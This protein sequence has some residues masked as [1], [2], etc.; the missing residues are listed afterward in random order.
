MIDAYSRSILAFYLAF[1]HPSS[2]SC[3]MIVR[4]CV[5]RWQ[6][7]PAVFVVD[8]GKEFES[9]YFESLLASYECVKKSRP[10]AQARFGSVCER[11]FGTTNTEMIYAL[12]G[13]T[14]ITKKVRIMTKSFDPKRQALWTLPDLHSILESFSSPSTTRPLIPQRTSRRSAFSKKV[15]HGRG[16]VPTVSFPTPKTSR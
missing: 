4:D 1:D 5:R 9:V 7:L 15:W 14:Q 6:R 12:A 2:Q 11:L 10:P 3:M 8:N 13:N 16:F